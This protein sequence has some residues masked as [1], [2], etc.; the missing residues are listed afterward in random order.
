[1]SAMRV[2]AAGGSWSAEPSPL[3]G[4]RPARPSNAPPRA[5]PQAWP[6]RCHRAPRPPGLAQQHPGRHARRRSPPPDLAWWAEQCVLLLNAAL[7]VRQGEP[8]SHLSLWR[9][10]TESVLRRLSE[11]DK[12]IVFVLWGREAQKWGSLLDPRHP[13][14]TAPHPASRGKDQIAFRRK[15]TFRRVN[16]ALVA[17]GHEESHLGTHMS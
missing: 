9:P 15:H 4:S 13:V 10:F 6:S 5:T 16:K 7:T 3:S 11:R 12:R 8:K 2:R 1:M 17:L 14:I